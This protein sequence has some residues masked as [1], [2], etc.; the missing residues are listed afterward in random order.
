MDDTKRHDPQAESRNVSARYR[1]LV[2]RGLLNQPILIAVAIAAPVLALLAPLLMRSRSDVWS[3]RRWW[4]AITV[5]MWVLGFTLYPSSQPVGETSG[6][7]RA[8]IEWLASPSIQGGLNLEVL[9][10]ILMFFALAAAWTIATRRFAAVVIG[11]V[12]LSL[13]IE[14]LQPFLGHTCS[15]Q[16]WTANS[17]GAIAGS[18]VALPQLRR[19]RQRDERST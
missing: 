14:L 17:L 8:C 2:I 5:L 4:L 12:L 7:L 6:A 10:N 11:G 13:T 9:L 19:W 3:R 15:G 18:L 1:R 16:D